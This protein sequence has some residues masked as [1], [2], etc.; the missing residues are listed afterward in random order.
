[1]RIKE[2]V[3]IQSIQAHTNDH[4]V[5][6]DDV[7]SIIISGQVNVNQAGLE[8]TS[9]PFYNSNITESW[10]CSAALSW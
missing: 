6:L 8:Y 5:L 9:M 7:F 10:K 2:C 4:L 3:Y 1:M